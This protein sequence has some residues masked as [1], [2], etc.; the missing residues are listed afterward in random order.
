[1]QFLMSLDTSP[2]LGCMMNAQLPIIT[3]Y[4]TNNQFTFA[5]AYQR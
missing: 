3:P 1:M 5:V 4:Q 2:Q